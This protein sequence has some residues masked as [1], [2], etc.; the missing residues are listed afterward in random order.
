MLLIEKNMYKS[1]NMIAGGGYGGMT[2]LLNNYQAV[3]PS[4]ASSSISRT[5][6]ENSR[7]A[8]ESM[9]S[10]VSAV[11]SINIVFSVVR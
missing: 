7:S 9:H 5:A 11:S 2:S 3:A 10:I 6:E 4:S 8:F 1:L